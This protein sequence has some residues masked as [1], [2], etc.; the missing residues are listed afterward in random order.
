MVAILCL[1]NREQDILEVGEVVHLHCTRQQ[2]H[3]ADVD[4]LCVLEN[5]NHTGIESTHTQNHNAKLRRYTIPDG[6]ITAGF[7]V[8]SHSALDLGKQ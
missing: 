6:T 4:I 3:Y 8:M 5:N 2:Y 1:H 7:E